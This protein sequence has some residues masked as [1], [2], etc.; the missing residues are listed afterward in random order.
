MFGELCSPTGPPPADPR[1]RCPFPSPCRGK[2]ASQGLKMLKTRA[3]RGF[4]LGVPSSVFTLPVDENAIAKKTIFSLQKPRL[5][6]PFPSACRGKA[7]FQGHAPVHRTP[8]P[9]GRPW[10]PR[11]VCLRWTFPPACRGK[12]HHGTWRALAM[13]VS[14]CLSR[15]RPLQGSPAMPPRPL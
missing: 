15:K 1:C 9:P 2:G 4:S 6:W 14:P 5:R 10:R 13:A 8:T 7:T 11:R 3:Q 12:G